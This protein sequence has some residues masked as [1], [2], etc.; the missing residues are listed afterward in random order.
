MFFHEVDWSNSIFFN[1]LVL[2]YSQKF[3]AIQEE[4]AD[5]IIGCDGAF[6]SVRRNMLQIPGFNFSQT[7]IDHGYIELCIPPLDGEVR[8]DCKFNQIPFSKFKEFES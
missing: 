4:T 1:F 8:V 3:S 6:S 7:Y 2:L 5:L